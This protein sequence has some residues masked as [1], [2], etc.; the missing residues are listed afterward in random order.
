M[1]NNADPDQLASLQKPTDL[2][3]HCLFRQGMSCSAREGL[4]VFYWAQFSHCRRWYEEVFLFNKITVCFNFSVVLDQIPNL[5]LVQPRT[6]RRSR[7]VLKI[8]LGVE[9]L[10]QIVPMTKKRRVSF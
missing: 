8:N 1:T 2:G 10:A 6:I 5:I 7:T 9:D 3:L 4:K